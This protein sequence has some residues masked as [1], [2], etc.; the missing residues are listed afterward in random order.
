MIKIRF[1][2]QIFYL[3]IKKMDDF[4]WLI[5]QFVKYFIM[6]IWKQLQIQFKLEIASNKK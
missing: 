5:I 3:N 2:N 1:S 4:L 6:K